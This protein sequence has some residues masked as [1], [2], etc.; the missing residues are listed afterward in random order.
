MTSVCFVTNEIYPLNKGGIGRMLYNIAVENSRRAAPADIHF[1]MV[2]QPDDVQAE[3]RA[4]LAGLAQVWFCPLSGLGH[5]GWIAAYERSNGLTWH[6]GHAYRQS[7]MLYAALRDYEAHLGRGFDFIEFPD[8][9]GWALASLE[10]KAA[11]LAFTGSHLVVRLHSTG[12]V[13]G[14]HQP[15]YEKTGYWT[16]CIQDMEY[17]SLA[18][19]DLV[20]GHLP[21]IVDHNRAFYG[22]PESWSDAAIVETPP[23]ELTDSE[24]RGDA[25]RPTGAGARDFI[26]SSRLQPFK[27]PDL[28][29]KA[30][31]YFLQDNPGYQGCF[32][33][34]SYGWDERY[35]ESLKQLIPAH[36]AARVRIETEVSASDRLAAIRAGI[37]VIPSNYESLCLFAFEASQLSDVLILN[38]QC[39]AFAGDDVWRHGENCL[40]FDGSARGLA[41]EMANALNLVLPEKATPTPT[42]PY[43][44]RAFRA[45]AAAADP[46]P[47]TLVLHGF[48]AAE[49]VAVQVAAVRPQLPEGANLLLMLPEA[50]RGAGGQLEKGCTLYWHPGDAVWPEDIATVLQGLE[51]AV[52]FAPAGTGFEPGYLARATAA[53]GA[54]ISLAAY[55]AHAWLDT[56]ERQ[57]IRIYAGGARSAAVLADEILP[58]GAVFRLDSL[59]KLLSTGDILASAVG[60]GWHEALV[61]T[62]ALD[63]HA[64]VVEPAA[65]LRLSGQQLRPAGNSLVDNTLLE[66]QMTRAVGTRP[67]FAP[68]VVLRA[69]PALPLAA[70]SLDLSHCLRGVKQVSPK[71][72]GLEWQPVAYRMKE[73]MLQ[74]HPMPDAAVVCELPV[75]S[76]DVADVTGV[77]IRHFGEGNPGVDFR[78]FVAASAGDAPTHASAWRTVMPGELQELELE[79][80]GSQ[81]FDAVYLEARPSNGKD[82]NYAWTFVDRLWTR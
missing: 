33:L 77:R 34:I 54:D 82:T 70:A 31:L 9:G 46:L 15:F 50:W 78:L 65:S 51:G 59:T 1:L 53:L 18:K 43:W 37:P 16:G 76:A 13:I 42:A 27:Q 23:L 66:Q 25:D 26:F 10:A 19:A 49:D 3:I 47:L 52:A 11:G 24:K 40:K 41:G 28:F 63:G 80:L 21:A 75:T 2:W 71:P 72:D 29:I 44:E 4:A 74:V 32:R 64:M 57:G 5:G 81:P 7:L 45:T 8:F 55:G 35:I 12:G 36:A 61:R 62:L 67:L 56:G 30:A 48:R 58:P 38:G 60:A 39:L 6:Y 22:F 69:L 68:G 14:A 79:G 73:R 17:L 20:V